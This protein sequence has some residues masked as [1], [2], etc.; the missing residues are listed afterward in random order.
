M[1]SVKYLNS[2]QVN[3]IED[4]TAWYLG[5]V[6]ARASYRLAKYKNTDMTEYATSTNA[7]VG[8]LRLGE[9]M[10]GQFNFRGN[11]NY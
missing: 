9:L 2:E 3:M 6:G 1:D 10:A 11:S 7:K 4:N 8:L 5:M